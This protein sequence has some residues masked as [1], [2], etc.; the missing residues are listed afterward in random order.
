[1]L[2][3]QESTIDLT[4]TSNYD[5][6]SVDNTDDEEIFITRSP[7]DTD[8]PSIQP[9]NSPLSSSSSTPRTS[10][11]S[12]LST[13]AA[14]RKVVAISPIYIDKPPFQPLTSTLSP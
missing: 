12:E 2:P 1:M 6:I 7:I 13:S 8:K 3:P 10:P 5:P 9:V 11:M 14:V 4:A